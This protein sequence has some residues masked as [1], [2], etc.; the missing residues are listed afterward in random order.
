MTAITASGILKHLDN[1]FETMSMPMFGNMNI[2]YV[3]NRLSAFR[4]SDDWLLA[5]NSIVWWPA[6]EGL[7][8]VVELVGPAVKGKE[9]FANDRVFTTGVV[10]S[11]DNDQITSVTV[12]D[13]PIDIHSLGAEFNEDVQPEIGFLASVALLKDHRESLLASPREMAKI[14]P[15][16]IKHLLTIDEWDHPDFD[17]PPSRTEAFPRIAAVLASGDP[18]QWRPSKNPNSHWSKWQPK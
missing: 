7:M 17:T 16:G 15:P 9:G 4:V 5:F 13:K 2:D 6:A 10:E 18:S 8:T 3:S 14:L 12:R 1:A 11:D